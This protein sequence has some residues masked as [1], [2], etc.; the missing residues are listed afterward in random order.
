MNISLAQ[1]NVNPSFGAQIV[2]S[3]YLEKGK[4]YALKDASIE[5]KYNF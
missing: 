3:K 1:Y 2:Q 5:E 4:R